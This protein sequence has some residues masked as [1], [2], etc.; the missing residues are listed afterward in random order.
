[1]AAAELSSIYFDAHSFL[2]MEFLNPSS[3]SSASSLATKRRVETTVD[4]GS[5]SRPTSGDVVLNPTHNPPRRRLVVPCSG[6]G[7]GLGH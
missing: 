7:R 3:T 6:G 5:F 2:G 4:S 1:M